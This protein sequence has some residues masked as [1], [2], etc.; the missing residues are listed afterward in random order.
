M[1][2]KYLD[3]NSTLYDYTVIVPKSNGSGALG[4]A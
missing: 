2:E 4:E 1:S 3:S